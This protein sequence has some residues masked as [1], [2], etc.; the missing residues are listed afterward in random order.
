[1]ALSFKGIKEWLLQRPDVGATGELKRLRVIEIGHTWIDLLSP[2]SAWIM[3]AYVLIVVLLPLPERHHWNIHAIILIVVI[4]LIY[5]LTLETISR[6]HAKS[7]DRPGL[8]ILRIFVNLTVISALIYASSGAESYFWCLYVVPLCQANM[9]LRR[10]NVFLVYLLTF[11]LYFLL[12]SSLFTTVP[13]ERAFGVVFTNSLTLFALA[14]VLYWLFGA[15]QAS[16]KVEY[17]LRASL[18]NTV[19][20]IAGDLDEQSLLDKIIDGATEMLDASGAGIYKYDEAK[21]ELTVVSDK[22]STKSIRGHKLKKG[23]G[24]AGRVVETG[25][26]MIVD[27]YSKW[28]FRCPEL[29]LNLFR[30]VVEVPLKLQSEIIG[31]LY[32]TDEQRKFTRRDAEVLTVLAGYAAIAMKNATLFRERRKNIARLELLDKV[33]SKMTY[34]A[35]LADN[36]MIILKEA[37]HAIDAVNGSIM[38]SDPKTEQ[39][40]MLAWIVNG[41]PRD[42]SE[43]SR[44]DGIAAWVA[45]NRQPLN[46]PDTEKDDRFV[47]SEDRVIRSIISVPI[48]ASEKLLCIINADDPEVNR[49]R[50]DDIELFATLGA[51]VTTM[52]ESLRLR[53][54]ILSLSSLPLKQL[55]PKIVESAFTLIRAD[56]AILSL[57]NPADQIMRAAIYPPTEAEGLD[58]PR[59]E[60]LTSQILSND[61]PQIIDD[62]QSHEGVNPQLKSR[63]IKSL[64]AVPLKAQIAIDASSKT[65]GV[66]FVCSKAERKFG[67]SEKQ[68]LDSLANRAATAITQGRLHDFQESLLASAFD[69]II[70]V[71]R[72]GNVKEFN[73]GAEKILG[74]SRDEVIDTNVAAYYAKKE[75]AQEVLELLLSPSNKGKLINHR[76]HVKTKNGKL[77]PITLSASLLEDG[78]VGFFRDQSEIETMRQHLQQ[79]P[80]LI[81][82]EPISEFSDLKR[83]L[84]LRAQGAMETLKAGA[85]WIY[86]YDHEKKA[87]QIPP[88]RYPVNGPIN[89]DEL[90]AFAKRLL[91]SEK[92]VLVETPDQAGVTDED[93]QFYY[94]AGGALKVNDNTLGVMLLGYVEPT[95]F[96]DARVFLIRNYISDV[97]NKLERDL[98]RCEMTTLLE[99]L[100]KTSLG[101][102]TQVNF[103]DALQDVLD[104]AV[105]ATRAKYGA[106]GIISPTHQIHP[107]LHSG[108]NEELL[109][110]LKPPSGKQGVLKRL[111]DEE[112]VINKANIQDHD[113]FV[114]FGPEEHPKIRSFLGAKI[115]LDGKPA[116]N[117]YVGNK[118]GASEFTKQDQSVLTI[119][120]TFASGA[121]K[122]FRERQH[123]TAKETVTITTVLLSQFAR[124]IAEERKEISRRLAELNSSSQLDRESLREIAE[125]VNRLDS[126]IERTKQGL[127]EGFS[128]LV[129]LDTILNDIA[130]KRTRESGIRIEIKRNQ[131]CLVRGNRFMLEWAGNVLIDNA[132]QAQIRAGR[133][134][135]MVTV[136]CEVADRLVR[137]TITDF[138]VGVPAEIQPQLFHD[139]LN[140]PGDRSNSS[141]LVGWVLRVHEGGIVVS[142]T[143]PSGTT[144]DF[145]LPEGSN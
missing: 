138:G 52:I 82:G 109:K 124:I 133:M 79:L 135:D 31:V 23:Q 18:A 97:A 117:I 90:L 118:R 83:V 16:R 61:E 25:D 58:S 35:S 93:K 15:A 36:L 112:E 34:A 28:E 17:Q 32:V 3:I 105:E 11:S 89:E 107:F 38:I 136:R 33:R 121:C 6:T 81:T 140:S 63:G 62:A 137:C 141:F 129:R 73:P 116:G 86:T 44:N 48:I 53:E 110:R 74:Y 5:V 99:G 69:A 24:M 12:S 30:A 131:A 72:K 47:K 98:E 102:T 27:D 13:T 114:N 21:D 103:D 120:G 57:T 2:F 1:M 7:Y 40:E 46:C 50:D 113:Y 76:T 37:L 45:E 66:L 43:H 68:I 84:E 51:H 20:A 119:L 125:S 87:L 71:D 123:A 130:R 26:P 142:N 41:K 67:A 22:G 101:L 14:V 39:L 96:D 49:F 55:Y 80:G 56:I 145:W 128:D 94:F 59:K 104:F 111:L 95:Q 70:A 108:I 10:R 60:G 122:S 143:G 9:Y 126:R 64:I 4:Q 106:L 139:K 100:Y 75:K 42:C 144:I 127:R 8:R 19:I 88:T 78:S 29:E 132:I 115:S 91:E 85:A 65:L 54:A 77:I 92:A 134:N